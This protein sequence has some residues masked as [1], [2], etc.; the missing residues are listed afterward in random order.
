VI[1]GER[2]AETSQSY[3]QE[4]SGMRAPKRLI[5]AGTLAGLALFAGGAHFR[6][7]LREESVSAVA[8]TVMVKRE[9]AS[10]ALKS[11]E[12]TLTQVQIDTLEVLRRKRLPQNSTKNSEQL[13]YRVAGNRLTTDGLESFLHELG[14]MRNQLARRLLIKRKNGA[15][16]IT[17]AGLKALAEQRKSK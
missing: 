16:K 13:Y 14:D 9:N 2:M 10:A 6:S 15:W 4:A 12:N 8:S 7:L 1:N 3:N 11:T 5:V 17:D